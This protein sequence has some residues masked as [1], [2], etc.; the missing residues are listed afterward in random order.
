MFHF[1]LFRTKIFWSTQILKLNITEYNDT[2]HLYLISILLLLLIDCSAECHSSQWCRINNTEPSITAAGRGAQVNHIEY[3]FIDATVRFDSLSDTLCS[4]ETIS[5]I[6]RHT[7][8]SKIIWPTDILSTHTEIEK[9][10]VDCHPNDAVTDA[11]STRDC[12]GQ[13]SF[14]E[15][16]WRRVEVG[17]VKS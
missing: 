14:G 11:S 3:F 1:I 10:L 17:A 9:R 16:T 15:M 5:R 8:W 7:I 13:M 12:V 4:H 2:K 6:W